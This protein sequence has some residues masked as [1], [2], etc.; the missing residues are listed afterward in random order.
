[1]NTISNFYSDLSEAFNTLWSSAISFKNGVASE[2]EMINLL[3]FSAGLCTTFGLVPQ[4]IKVLQTGDTQAISLGMYIIFTVG[5]ALWLAFGIMLNNVWI[6]LWNIL[7][8]SFAS[9]ILSYK[10]YDTFLII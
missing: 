10:L 6:K 9:I 8:L 3:G 2:H 1:M 7:S 4:V 5:L